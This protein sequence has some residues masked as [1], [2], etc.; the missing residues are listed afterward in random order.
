MDKITQVLFSDIGKVTTQYVEVPHQQLKPHEVRIA[1]VFYGICG[2]DLHV[3]KGGH[4]FAKPPVVPGH[5]IAARVTEVGSDVKNVQPGDHVVVDPIMACME[6]RACKAGRFNLC[7]PPQVA[8]FRAPGFARSQ[9]IVPAR[10]CHVAPASLPANKPPHA[11]HGMACYST[12]EIIDKTAD[13]LTLRMPLASPWPWQGEVIQTFLLENDALVL[14]L[15]VHSYADTF[16]A[17]AGWHP[18]FAKKLTPQNTESLQVLFDADWQEEAGSDELPT[19]NRISPQ[20]GPWDDCFGFYDGVKVKLLWPGKLA[21]TMTS[22]A[23]SLVV[24]DKQPDA[25]CINPLT[26]APNA[27]NLTPEFVTPDKP[28]VIETRWQFTPES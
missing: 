23:N 17:S 6:C 19:G 5:E 15:E 9:H 24:F 7:E 18:W 14:Q 20:V 21:M 13:S 16:P 1:P 2:S 3:L 8:G 25:T 10:N 26:Q 22:S 12:W 27:I 11:L 4:P 28:L